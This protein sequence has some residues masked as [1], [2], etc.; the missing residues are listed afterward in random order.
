MNNPTF[1]VAFVEYSSAVEVENH[2]HLEKVDKT[3]IVHQKPLDEGRRRP[4]T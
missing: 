2:H 4:A 3:H 1:V